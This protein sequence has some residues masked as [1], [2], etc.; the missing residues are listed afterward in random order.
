MVRLPY[1]PS[2]AGVFR[3][4]HGVWSLFLG[5]M[6]ILVGFVLSVVR[7][8]RVMVFS[9]EWH[10]SHFRRQQRLEYSYSHIDTDV[11][12]SYSIHW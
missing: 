1:P 10:S 9:A 11:R 12:F 2:S 4:S 3:Q 7:L 8:A 5:Y 6:G